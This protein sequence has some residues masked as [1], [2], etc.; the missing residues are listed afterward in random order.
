MFDFDEVLDGDEEEPAEEE[1]LE[2][3]DGPSV[4]LWSRVQSELV[5]GAPGQVPHLSLGS[6]S[7][8]RGGEDAASFGPRR[9]QVVTCLRG[10]ALASCVHAST[11]AGM[12][13]SCGADFQKEKL[14][15]WNCAECEYDMCGEC[16]DPQEFELPPA[17]AP[18]QTSAFM[19][20]LADQDT[21]TVAWAARGIED[22]SAS[23]SASELWHQRARKCMYD[24]GAREAVPQTTKLP[25]AAL[26]WEP[27]A[28]AL[29]TLTSGHF[30]PRRDGRAAGAESQRDADLISVVCSTSDGRCDFHPLLYE[31][32][33]QQRY[34]PKELVVV[35]TGSAP[36]SFFRE[37]AE[38]DQRVTY[39]FFQ[40]K[41]ETQCKMGHP[42]ERFT[43]KNTSHS[44]D[45]C[46]RARLPKGTPMWGCRTCNYDR[47]DECFRSSQAP[48]SP[49]VGAGGTSNPMHAVT[50]NDNPLEIIQFFQGDAGAQE[51]QQRE[52]WTK[53]VK[54]NVACCLA[55]GTV[56]A[57]F[58]DGCLY[59]PYYLGFMM[60]EVFKA[61]VE[62]TRNPSPAALTLSRWYTVDLATL[63]FR[64]V[65]L[66]EA[67]KE[68][69]PDLYSNSF[70][71]VY[72][73]SAWEL[74]PFPDKE[75]VGHED[76]GFMKRLKRRGVPIRLVAE[77]DLVACG[78]HRLATCGSGD[79]AANINYSQVLNDFASRGEPLR[80]APQSFEG[81]VPRVKEV[82]YEL[83][84]RR[85]LHVKSIIDEHGPIYVCSNCDFGVALQSSLKDSSKKMKRKWAAGF[86][87]AAGFIDLVFDVAEFPSAGGAVAEGQALNW[88]DS[89][90][91]LRGWISR[92]AI[93]RNCGFHLGWRHEK[94][95]EHMTMCKSP[96][97][98]YREFGP[99]P[100][101]DV[102]SRQPGKLSMF[103]K[104]EFP[105]YCCVHC[106]ENG[107]RMHDKQC[108]KCPPP[109]PTGP[110]FWTLSW[111]S[112]RERRGPGER[113]PVEKAPGLRR[114][115]QADDGNRLK[116]N[117]CPAGH[118]L[119]CYGVQQP[120]C[121]SCSLCGDVVDAGG[122]MWGCSACGYDV[123][124]K[125]K[126][127]C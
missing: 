75:F 58:E 10:H 48:G 47:C 45:S 101:K 53:G 62:D 81:L 43:T 107:G 113:P 30:D 114:S 88:A 68:V 85:E 126:P 74:Q 57:H 100:V 29:F 91:W 49:R 102:I 63:R 3:D 119:R 118:E 73:R 84:L 95:I 33:S 99:T 80:A 96:G 78:W 34:E 122:Q 66:L 1:S 55:R 79:A 39:R 2:V 56:I 105:G 7:S 61:D 32:F 112:L 31:N 72:T 103:G 86:S 52:Q 104:K 93:C 59:S 51:I 125:C 21:I 37:K 13:R 60:G 89:T 25:K 64:R 98:G 82:A 6:L 28:G 24:L 71:Y 16:L 111:R 42:L 127:A 8:A 67:E 83:L 123:C 109:E 18:A 36:S 46:G 69:P 12:C 17:P 124:R 70:V 90:P 87:K 40:V 35:H 22:A 44:C 97:C 117:E 38:E 92:A 15:R 115:G 106:A 27:I 4:E 116:D 65:D 54:W 120:C 121:Y 23:L 20:D 9:T 26:E 108:M 41:S 76:M 94:A 5:G 14:A 110:I 50:G 11:W 19:G 77:E